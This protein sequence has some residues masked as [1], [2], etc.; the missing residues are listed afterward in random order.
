MTTKT[1]RVA[2]LLNHLDAAAASYDKMNLAKFKKAAVNA[3]MNA[4]PLEKEAME[5]MK[6]DNAKRVNPFLEFVKDKIP[7]VRELNPDLPYKQC[8]TIIGQMWKESHQPKPQPLKPLKPSQVRST[9]KRRE[10]P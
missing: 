3:W 9:R 2:R 7:E 1:E 6:K 8:L 5:K 10:E 4:H